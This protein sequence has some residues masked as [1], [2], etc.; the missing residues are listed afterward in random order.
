MTS[1]VQ[2]KGMNDGLERRHSTGP[3]ST[4]TTLSPYTATN[5]TTAHRQST[6]A[7][8]LSHSPSNDESPSDY[9]TQPQ[10]SPS[11]APTH[12]FWI[13]PHSLFTRSIPVYDLTSGISTPYTGLSPAYKAAVQK[14]LKD[15]CPTPCY[16]LTR[17]NWL[18]LRYTI[19]DVASVPVA[20]W[21]HPWSSVGEALLTFPADSTHSTHAVALRNKRWGRRTETFVMDS[22]TYEW[23]SDSLLVSQYMTLYKVLGSQRAEVGKFAAKRWGGWS[24][25]GTFVVDTNEVDELVAVLSLAVVLKKKRQRAAKRHGA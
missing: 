12:T 18:G 15:H 6:S 7:I 23:A 9:E 14:A 10:D 1:A 16:T 13:T 25:G 19:T 3:T 20:E 2:L 24:T 21:K 5:S 4:S 17:Q 8:D 11:F 22:V